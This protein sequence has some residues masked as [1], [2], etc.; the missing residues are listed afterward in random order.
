MVT[1]FLQTFG[2]KT[3]LS[4]KN[5]QELIQGPYIYIERE[6]EREREEEGEDTKTSLS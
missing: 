6:R 3:L 1:Y 5:Q 4:M 2:N